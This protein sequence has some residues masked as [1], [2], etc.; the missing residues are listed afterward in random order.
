MR[1][2]ARF[3]AT[4]YCK[5]SYNWY[6]SVTHPAPRA[7]Q[8]P[9]QDKSILNMLKGTGNRLAESHYPYYEKCFSKAFNSLGSADFSNLNASSIIC[10]ADE[11][12]KLDVELAQERNSFITGVHSAASGYPFG[13]DDF[14]VKVRFNEI[15]N[16]FPNPCKVLPNR[17]RPSLHRLRQLR[18]GANTRRILGILRLSQ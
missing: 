8:F 7:K 2:S 10:D 6:N 11:N 14:K 15:A 1:W 17:L 5:A 4:L 12:G 13:E 18:A 16:Y 9:L 3:L